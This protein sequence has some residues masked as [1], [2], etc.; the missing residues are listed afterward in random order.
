MT[1]E[2]S[3]Q[4]AYAG[5]VVFENTS[6]IILLSG[7]AGVYILAF[8][9]SMHIILRK[10]N[11]RWAYKALI[12]LLLMAFALAALF[13]CLD[14]ALG[15]LEVK[16][17]FVVSLS[18]GLIAQELA[19][20]SKVSGMSIISDWA[21]NFTF[22]IADTAIVWR[23][24]ALWTENKLVKWTLLIILL[25]DIGINIAD[26]V[27]DT[28]VTINALNTDNNSVTFDSLSPA[29]NLT[30]N[31]VATFLIAHRAW[32]HHQSTPA[33]L[34]NN[35]TEVGAILLLMVESGAIFGMVQ[36]TNIILHALDIH[37]A[38]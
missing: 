38:A 37:A 7:L 25:A 4:I 13:A 5:S 15:L 22:L 8:T 36:V 23:A 32:K 27:V 34:H 17:G 19:A 16:F 33:I 1:P 29:L 10:N 20:D 28:K 14:I 2:E 11:N 18:G 31:I 6:T 35:K 24:W 21:A 12:A 30:V 26:A 9:I 3:E